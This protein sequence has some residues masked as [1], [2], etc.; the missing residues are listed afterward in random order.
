MF[1]SYEKFNLELNMSLR[2]KRTVRNINIIRRSK[3]RTKFKK[4][5]FQM[6]FSD[7][8]ALIYNK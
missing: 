3:N 8:T 5:K 4:T 2:V 1:R 6:L 7:H